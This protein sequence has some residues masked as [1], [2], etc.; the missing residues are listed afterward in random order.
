MTICTDTDSVSQSLDVNASLS[1]GFAD[2]SVSAKASWAQSLSLTS[3]SVA[4]IVH[5]VVVKGDTQ[6]NTYSLPSTL[7]SSVQTFFND[8]GD[9]FVSEIVEGGEYYAAFIFDSTSESQ[10][11]QI[12]ASLTGSSGMLSGSLSVAVNNASSSSSL[13]VRTSQQM[14]GVSNPTY[15]ANDP[16]SIVNFASGFGGNGQTID[17]PTVLAYAVTGYEHVPGTPAGFGPVAANRALL[18]TASATPF[19]DAMSA[20][21]ALSNQVNAIKAMY[22][23]YNY[24]GDTLFIKNAL[25]VS[26][27]LTALQ[28][29]INN[30][31]SNVTGTFAATSLTSLG[32]GVPMVAYTLSPSSTPQ[33]PPGLSAFFDVTAPQ[34][35]NGVLPVSITLFSGPQS[36]PLA[37]MAIQTTYS[38]GTTTAHGAAQTQIGPLTIQNGDAIQSVVVSS[39]PWVFGGYGQV[40]DIEVTTM[41]GQSIGSSMSQA[42]ITKSTTTAPP[43]I[44]GFAGA[45]NF[46][47][48]NLQPITITLTPALWIHPIAP[49][50][51]QTRRSRRGLAQ[52][53]A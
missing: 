5:A 52:A 29:L 49:Q 41:Q 17:A 24:T 33:P 30:I 48:L 19:V 8:Y 11:E 14:L 9:S 2:V 18:G 28:T 42:S 36:S 4:V 34:V 21:T 16:T 13:T 12:Q 46:P 40:W 7:P 6:A 3:T 43:A 15:P 26:S 23:A 25:Q 39:V 35:A 47:L 50:Q 38:D 53:Q 51:K 44:I 32:Y 45:C 20:L 27:D 31:E 10:Q 37:I 22:S 1:G